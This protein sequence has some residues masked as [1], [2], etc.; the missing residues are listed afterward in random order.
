MKHITIRNFG[1]ISSAEVDLNKFNVVVGPQSAGKSCLLKI[2][3]YCTWVEKRIQLS[4]TFEKFSTDNYFLDRLLTFHKLEGYLRKDTYIGYETDS[5]AFSY[6]NSTSEFDFSWKADGRWDYHQPK[7]SYIPAERNMVAAISNWFEVNLGDNN[8]RNFMSDWEEARKHVTEAL[9]IMNLG[10]SYRYDEKTGNDYVAMANDNE[11]KLTN[12]SSGLQSLV[13]LLVHLEY[14]Y[15]IR[16][17]QESKENILRIA[18]NKELLVN[19]YKTLFLPGIDERAIVE[20]RKLY[21]VGQFAFYFNNKEDADRCRKIYD[22]FVRAGHNEIF[23]EEPEQ[24]LFPPTQALL[25]NKLTDYVNGDN[26]SLFIATH[27]P[28]VVTSFLEKEV[29]DKDLSLFLAL[30]EEDGR[31]R[32]HTV[33]EKEEQ[34]IYEYGVDVFYNI[35]SFGK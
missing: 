20:S 9:P 15:S 24:N 29:L 6:D 10:V 2:A 17:K 16:H 21:L 8:I 12:T 34:E 19:I 23:L 26:G 28:Y 25:I 32:I 22:D 13:P 3:C 14:L 5:M 27:S 1:P 31:Y 35:E 4:Q 33:S 30:A 18:E 7:V 11:L